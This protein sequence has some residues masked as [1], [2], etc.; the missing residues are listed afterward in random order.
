MKVQLRWYAASH[1][2]RIQLRDRSFGTLPQEPR[3]AA[4]ATLARRGQ[5]VAHVTKAVPMDRSLPAVLQSATPMPKH[6]ALVLLQDGREIARGPAG[7][8]VLL[9]AGLDGVRL[10]PLAAAR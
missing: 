4:T 8:R 6:P 3:V 9:P 1:D 7:N 2:V 10:D 5:P